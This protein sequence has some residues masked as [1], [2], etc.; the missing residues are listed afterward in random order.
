M[1]LFSKRCGTEARMDTGAS[2]DGDT[3]NTDSGT[4]AGTN[5][6]ADT[7]TSFGAETGTDAGTVAEGAFSALDIGHMQAALAQ[8]EF[9]RTQGEVPVGA[10]VVAESGLGI[11][12][13]FNRAQSD[14]DPTGHARTEE[15]Q[16]E[17]HHIMHEPFGIFCLEKNRAS[18]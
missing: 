14:H 2:T 6:G 4:N 9:A 18:I 11:A 12:A 15:P 17:N 3:G 10:V 16:S 8:A 1:S 13:G 7:G 5:S